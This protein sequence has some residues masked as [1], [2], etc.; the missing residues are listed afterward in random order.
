MDEKAFSKKNLESNK[1]NSIHQWGCLKTVSVP[2][3]ILPSKGSLQLSRN[4][5]ESRESRGWKKVVKMNNTS[6]LK[7]GSKNTMTHQIN[8]KTEHNEV[9]I[10]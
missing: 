7:L 9:E 4:K 3:T 6:H 10:K 1:N 8:T 5:E 2:I